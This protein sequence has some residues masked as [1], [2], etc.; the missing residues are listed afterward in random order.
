[1]RC[2]VRLNLVAGLLLAFAGL[3]VAE[4][5]NQ[6]LRQLEEGSTHIFTGELRAVYRSVKRGEQFEDTRALAEVLIDKVE[7]GGGL[8]PGQAVFLRFW[9]QEWI[10]Q[11][12]PPPSSGGHHIP[13]EGTRVRAYVERVK[14]GTLEVL[15]PNGLTALK[16]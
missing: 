6:T 5:P 8:R 9:N 2:F 4:V 13:A 15:L 3:A 10:G 16:D 14:D 12:P 1:M 11:G 7:K